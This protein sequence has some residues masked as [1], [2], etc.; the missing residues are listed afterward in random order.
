MAVNDNITCIYCSTSAVAYKGIIY[1]YD[2][3][4]ICITC[5]EHLRQR[6]FDKYISTID[7]GT[8]TS[9]YCAVM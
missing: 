4:P 6:G 7:V 3:S 8:H 9:S 1:I 2:S 5:A